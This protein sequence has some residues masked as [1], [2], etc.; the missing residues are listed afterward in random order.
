MLFECQYSHFPLLQDLFDTPNHLVLVTNKGIKRKVWLSTTLGS[1]YY[2]GSM[3]SCAST[4]WPVMG[5]LRPGIEAFMLQLPA[6][7]TTGLD[8]CSSDVIGCVDPLE[9]LHCT[10]LDYTVLHNNTLHCI[11][12]Q[13]CNGLSSVPDC[14]MIHDTMNVLY[15]RSMQRSMRRRLL[16]LLFKM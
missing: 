9:S 13:E 14:T 8:Q 12:S 7:Q 11:Y 4:Q 10:A 2:W 1:T 5:S 16:T 3:P 6:G 15:W